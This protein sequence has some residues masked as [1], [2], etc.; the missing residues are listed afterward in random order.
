MPSAITEIIVRRRWRHAR[1]HRVRNTRVPFTYRRRLCPSGRR[2][3]RSGWARRTPSSSGR[4]AFSHAKSVVAHRRYCWPNSIRAHTYARLSSARVHARIPFV[5]FAA[6][7]HATG[8][9]ASVEK[10]RVHRTCAMTTVSTGQRQH[11]YSV[12]S[13]SV[14]RE[15]RRRLSNKTASAGAATRVCLHERERWKRNKITSANPSHR[16]CTC[17]RIATFSL[18]SRGGYARNLPHDISNVSPPAAVPTT[19]YFREPTF[20][21]GTPP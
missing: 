13:V 18:L 9:A 1:A 4:F 12:Y 21:W 11:T 3:W 17:G 10:R 2:R 7:T 5:S 14:E 15:N 20:E 19:V 8:N 16:P 6:E